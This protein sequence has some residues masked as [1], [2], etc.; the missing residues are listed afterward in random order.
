LISVGV[1][2]GC[3]PYSLSG[4]CKRTASKAYIRRNS[5]YARILNG[6][7]FRVR[8]YGYVKP[9]DFHRRGNGLSLLR[10]ER[11][12]ATFYGVV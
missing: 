3:I 9:L 10:A 6:V 4:S 2:Y 11:R 12:A 8:G 1:R 5:V 7:A